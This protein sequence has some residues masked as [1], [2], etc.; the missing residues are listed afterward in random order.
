MSRYLGGWW[1]GNEMAFSKLP[2]QLDSVPV[3]CCWCGAPVSLGWEGRR[4]EKSL[5]CTTLPHPAA[6]RRRHGGIHRDCS[7]WLRAVHPR[8]PGAGATLEA[9]VT[10]ASSSSD[11]NVNGTSRWALAFCSGERLTLTVAAAIAL[12]WGQGWGMSLCSWALGLNPPFRLQVVRRSEFPSLWRLSNSPL[13]GWPHF[14]YPFMSCCTWVASPFWLL[15]VTLL[16]K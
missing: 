11:T 7:R 8:G 15:W 2:C 1:P 4:K 16:C 13:C 12:L 10:K 14:A 9:R 5:T 3:R 6:P